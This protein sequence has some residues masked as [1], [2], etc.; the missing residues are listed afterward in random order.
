MILLKIMAFGQD[1]AKLT[2]D[3]QLCMLVSMNEV[4]IKLLQGSTVNQ[5][6]LGG[7]SV[8]SLTANCLIRMRQKLLQ[9][10][11]RLSVT[12]GLHLGLG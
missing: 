4:D 2:R 10:L 11:P 6:V 8:H 7:H 12:C 3:L 5:T 1:I 9:A